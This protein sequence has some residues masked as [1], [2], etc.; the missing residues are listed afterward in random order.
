MKLDPY[1]NM[2]LSRTHPDAILSAISSAPEP[3]I[4]A[5]RA[6]IVKRSSGRMISEEHA[7]TCTVCGTTS[8][9]EKTPRYNEAV[10]V[11]GHASQDERPVCLS[12]VKENNWRKLAPW[13][14]D[15]LLTP[16]AARGD[17]AQLICKRLKLLRGD[18][19]IDAAIAEVM[20][21]LLD[22]VVAL[23]AAYGAMDPLKLDITPHE[24]RKGCGT[25]AYVEEDLELVFGHRKISVGRGQVKAKV[26]KVQP[27][28]RSC[29]RDSSA[30]SKRKAKQRSHRSARESLGL[31][32]I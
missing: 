13:R 7:V 28:C 2:I 10:S 31:Q 30:A 5:Y 24:C 9:S 17:L 12:C 1:R 8:S 29:R 18:D 6:K 25:T 27:Y 15:I 3:S 20:L 16:D 22:E 4:R 32:T 14:R 26:P 11:F 23:D 21:S 19:Q